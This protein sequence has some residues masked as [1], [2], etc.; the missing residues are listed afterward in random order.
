MRSQAE[1]RGS[2]PRPQH[3][4]ALRPTA[5]PDG[6]AL[7]Q[8]IRYEPAPDGSALSAR[9]G[10]CVGVRYVVTRASKRREFQV[11]DRVWME[12]DGSIVNP[13]ANGW[14][15][16]GDVIDATRGWAIEPDAKWA[17]AMRAELEQKLAALGD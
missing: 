2:N 4:C 8:T 12:P 6:P 9:I 14:M 3:K 13:A 5:G 1:T 17:S 16:P 15:P 11:G 7:E 10:M